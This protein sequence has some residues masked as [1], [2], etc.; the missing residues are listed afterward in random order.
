MTICYMRFACWITKGTDTLK[1][2]CTYWFRTAKVVMRT[3]LNVT[4][5]TY[6][7][8]WYVGILFLMALAF[9]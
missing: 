1:L 4:V 7:S 8:V 5:Y 2:C 9:G 6:I 3:R